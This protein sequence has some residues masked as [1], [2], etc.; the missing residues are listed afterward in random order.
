MVTCTGASFWGRPLCSG[1]I[2]KTSEHR[3]S[4]AQSFEMQYKSWKCLTW[5]SFHDCRPGFRWHPSLPR[6]GTE[7]CPCSCWAGIKP[8]IKTEGRRQ[9]W[10]LLQVF[11]KKVDMEM[12][13]NFPLPPWGMALVKKNLCPSLE[14]SG[15]SFC[16]DRKQPP[17]R[18]IRPVGLL[19]F[20][21]F[22]GYLLV[23]GLSCSLFITYLS[24]QPALAL[25]FM[26]LRT[27][28]QGF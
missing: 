12:W 7:G 14:K 28:E 4:A 20:C 18:Q 22:F 10:L 24:V 8:K 11:T 15:G 13:K 25:I 9:R 16:G 5:G 17:E 21:V 19:I 23:I 6:S 2:W 27:K 3:E 26:F 1:S